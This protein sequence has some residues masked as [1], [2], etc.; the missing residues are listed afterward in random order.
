[1]NLAVLRVVAD[2]D[3]VR[4][5]LARHQLAVETAWSAGEVDELGRVRADS[6]FN[7]TLADAESAAE[8]VALTEGWLVA[9]EAFLRELATSG[10]SGTLDVGFSVNVDRPNRAVCFTPA[11]LQHCVDAGVSLEVSAYL[12][13]PSDEAAEVSKSIRR[14]EL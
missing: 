5:L 8:L 12:S 9:N 3:I 7:T 6:G 2:G 4:A 14:G 1:M 10:A 11:L 13:G